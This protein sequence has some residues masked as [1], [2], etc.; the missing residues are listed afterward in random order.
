MA[1]HV[2]VLT[3]HPLLRDRPFSAFSDIR[4]QTYP[5]VNILHTLLA[6]KQIIIVFPFFFSPCKKYAAR[7]ERKKKK[8]RD[9]LHN[10]FSNFITK[11]AK[12]PSFEGK[13]SG[14]GACENY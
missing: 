9:S 4:E 14:F 6:P 7:K 11:I 2:V 3:D 12:F 8:S 5:G 1:R 13:S 10:S